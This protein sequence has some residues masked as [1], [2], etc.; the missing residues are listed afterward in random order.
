M[1]LLG[2][3]VPLALRIF[4]AAA[5]IADDVG[6]IVIIALF[7]TASLSLANLA[8]S[9]IILAVLVGLNRARVY[10]PLPYALVGVLFWLAVLQSGV[11]PTLAGVL[12]AFAIPTRTSPNASALQGQAVS[13]LQSID[14]PVVG[15]MNEPRYRAAVRELEAMAERLLSPADRL[16]RDIQPW[17]A[18]LVLPVFAFANGGVPLDIDPRGFLEPVSLGVLF[19]LVI[20]K[21]LGITLGAWLPTKFGLA[22]KPDEITW[23]QMAGAGFL[24]GIGFTMSFFIAELAF[25]DEGVLSLVKLSVLVASA[26]AGVAGWLVLLAAHRGFG[27]N[28]AG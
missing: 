2:P 15:E 5:A 28:S 26:L 27:R 6:A 16:A 10:H 3:R 25:S 18:Y 20:G 9:A 8:L 1:A 22:T 13:I 21:P 17:S 12:L 11:H 14:A 7:Y 23:H 4:V 24:C 19:G